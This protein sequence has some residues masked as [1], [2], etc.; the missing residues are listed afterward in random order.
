[1]FQ[2]PVLTSRSAIGTS[3][4]RRRLEIW[5]PLSLALRACVALSVL[6][7]L[8][9]SVP[10]AR[11]RTAD[12]FCQVLGTGVSISCAKLSVPVCQ[13]LLGIMILLS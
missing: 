2:S 3:E 4:G 5:L 7:D 11:Y 13:S 9:I 8:P 6:H 12:L 1:V 10:I